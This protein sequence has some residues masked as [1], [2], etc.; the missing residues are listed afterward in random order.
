MSLKS[1]HVTVSSTVISISNVVLWRWN[2]LARL[3]DNLVCK[4]LIFAPKA[5]S[6]SSRFCASVIH[7]QSLHCGE[8]PVIFRR[9]MDVRCGSWVTCVGFDIVTSLKWVESFSL[10]VNC[11]AKEVVKRGVNIS[12]DSV[13]EAE[14]KNYYSYCFELCELRVMGSLYNIILFLLKWS[15]ISLQQQEK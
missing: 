1:S 9:R 2:L 7:S 11:V 8:R 10:S 6:S 5:M 14:G 13:C 3:V 4:D 15:K 12:M